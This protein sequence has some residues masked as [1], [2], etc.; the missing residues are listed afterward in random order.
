[1]LRPALT[2]CMYSSDESQWLAS[3]VFICPD[4]CPS[5]YRVRSLATSCTTQCAF[6]STRTSGDV[7]CVC[8]NAVYRICSLSLVMVPTTLPTS[9]YT[10]TSYFPVVPDIIPLPIVYIPFERMSWS[11]LIVFA[12]SICRYVS[13]FCLYHSGC[14][15]LSSRGTQ[16]PCIFMFDLFSPCLLQQRQAARRHVL[17]FWLHEIQTQGTCMT[18]LALL[19]CR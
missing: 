1:M 11:G 19:H 12:A 8:V 2:A 5:W 10:L 3:L 9:I 13:S 6:S 7:S 16:Y 18:L 4:V 14:F 15:V 17:E